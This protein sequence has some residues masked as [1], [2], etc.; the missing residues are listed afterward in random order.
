MHSSG[1]F[2]SDAE[3]NKFIVPLFKTTFISTTTSAS[4]TTTTTIIMPEMIWGKTTASEIDQPCMEMENVETWSKIFG[5]EVGKQMLLCSCQ[6][7]FACCK[8]FPHFK[9][10][11]LIFGLEKSHSNMALVLRAK[12]PCFIKVDTF[13]DVFLIHKNSIQQKLKFKLKQVDHQIAVYRKPNRMTL[14]LG[15]KQ[16]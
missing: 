7:Q 4:T 1:R 10:M 9:A 6:L 5:S 16:W 11:L 2:N 14:R 3:N 15:Q 13:V 8:Q 12:G